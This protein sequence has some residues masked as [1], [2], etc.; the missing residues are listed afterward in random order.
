MPDKTDTVLRHARREGLI[1]GLAWLASTIYCCSY[2]W[3]F[4]YGDAEHP[5]TKA[6][7][8]PILGIP[9][10]CFWGYI[11]PWGVCALF[12]VWFAGFY[13]ID[14]DLGRDHSIELD[15]DIREGAIDA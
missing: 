2:S 4:G 6:D 12:T 15:A 3:L 8:R 9:S 14:D 5:L 13:M 7:V 11:V 10:W 1:I